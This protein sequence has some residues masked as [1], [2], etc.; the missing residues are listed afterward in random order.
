VLKRLPVEKELVVR[1]FGRHLGI[2][3][4]EMYHL[5]KDN[6]SNASFAKQILIYWQ[7]KTENNL[8]NALGKVK[9]NIMWFK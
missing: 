3:D 6:H 5:R 1:M 4:V 2:S 9:M 7:K 8:I